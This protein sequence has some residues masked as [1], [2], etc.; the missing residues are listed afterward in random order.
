MAAARECWVCEDG[1]REDGSRGR[2]VGRRG[3]RSD[4]DIVGGGREW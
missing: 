2:E 3:S 1:K 4:D